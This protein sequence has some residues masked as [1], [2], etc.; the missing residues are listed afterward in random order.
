[1]SLAAGWGDHLARWRAEITEINEMIADVNLKQP[2]DHM[3]IFKLSLDRELAR[4]GARESL[5]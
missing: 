3:E 4:V 5:T 2:G 1:M